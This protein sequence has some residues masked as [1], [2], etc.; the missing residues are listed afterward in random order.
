[1][2][3]RRFALSFRKSHSILRRDGLGLPDDHLQTFLLSILW[4]SFLPGLRLMARAERPEVQ[5]VGSISG[6]GQNRVAL[7]WATLR[8]GEP[9]VVLA[10][11]ECPVR[12]G[13]GEDNSPYGQVRR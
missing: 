3:K 4:L 8:E 13:K 10:E 1:M 2:Q 5:L 9:D 11:G 6:W 7:R 12:R